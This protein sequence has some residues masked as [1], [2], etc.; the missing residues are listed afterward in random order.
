MPPGVLGEF[1][2]VVL[3]AVAH[4]R[5]EG[6]SSTIREA[7]EARTRRRVSRGAVYITLDRLEAKGLLASALGD[8]LPQ[9]GGRPRRAYALT[10]AGQRAVRHSVSIFA[11]MQAGLEPLLKKS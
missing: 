2:F 3:L 8:P 4:L 7:I 9:R 11:S 1:E 5:G 6:Y 10:A